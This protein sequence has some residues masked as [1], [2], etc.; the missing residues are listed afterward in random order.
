MAALTPR[1]LLA[2]LAEADETLAGAREAF[3]RAF[4]ACRA[5]RSADAQVKDAMALLDLVRARLCALADL[6]IGTADAPPTGR[7]RGRPRR[8]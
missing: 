7:Q 3:A 4:V 1:A 2:K 8:S 5:G 6:Q